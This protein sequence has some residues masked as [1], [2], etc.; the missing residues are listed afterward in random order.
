MHC[1]FKMSASKSLQVS[2]PTRLKK[3]VDIGCHLY[4][5]QRKVLWWRARRDMGPMRNV[6]GLV[7]WRIFRDTQGQINMRLQS[8][9][10]TWQKDLPISLFK[11]I[12][13]SSSVLSFQIST[14]TTLCR[15]NVNIQAKY[16]T[17]KTLS[18]M[19]NRNIF[20][21]SNLKAVKRQPQSWYT[22]PTT[23]PDFTVEILPY[24]YLPS[25]FLNTLRTGDADLHFNTRLFSLHNTLNYAIHRACL[26][27]VLQ[28]DVCRNLTSLWIKF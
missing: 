19:M 8:G 7:P 18:R 4:I 28:T 17:D 2:K 14:V 6:R 20:F 11:I 13:S 3:M 27:M 25:L 16:V 26:R 15:T 12:V 21:R 10:N 5:L 24:C 23:S 9:Y 1:F 22:A